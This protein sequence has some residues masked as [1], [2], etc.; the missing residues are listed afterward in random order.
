MSIYEQ[1]LGAYPQQTAQQQHNARIEVAQKIALAGLARSDF[2]SKAAFV[3]A[4][5]FVLHALSDSVGPVCGEDACVA[6]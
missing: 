1:M 5:A 4:S 3:G 2:F 6:V